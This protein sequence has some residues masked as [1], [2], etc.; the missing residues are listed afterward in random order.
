MLSTLDTVDWPSLTHAYGSAGNVPGAIR[1]LTSDDPEDWVG[2]LSEVY[3]CVCHQTCSVYEATVPAV[4]FLIELLGSP[5]VRC[6]GRILELLG[7]IAAASDVLPTDDAEEWRDCRESLSAV[8]SGLATYLAL[9]SDPDP[10]LR[11]S[12]PYTLGRLF[13]TAAD[14]TPEEV[15][16]RDPLRRTADRLRARLADEPADLVRA[17][18][19]FA[20]AVLADRDETLLGPVRPLVD[21][22]DPAV[23]IAA[24][25]AVAAREADPPDAVVDVLAAA[26]EDG[27]ETDR[28]FRIPNPMEDRHHPL[29]KAYR[30][31]GLLEE[32]DAG[33]GFDP[34]DVGADEDLRFPWYSGWPRFNVINALCGLPRRHLPRMMPGFLTAIRGDNQYAFETVSGPILEYVSD[35]ALRDIDATAA[36]LNEHQR[37]ALRALHELDGV[38]G[39]RSANVIDALRRVGLTDYATDRERVGRLASP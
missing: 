33:T 2:G 12:A 21:D 25:L 14:G 16:V 29:W 3:D 20:T 18:L 32:G 1:R 8:W 37:A 26:L 39:T 13:E 7:D 9:T 28:L 10:R 4:P 22:D 35:G 38:W 15:R 17:G 36:D 6:R 34:A 19:I 27:K 5:A 24:A 11:L 30:R 23:R 31:A